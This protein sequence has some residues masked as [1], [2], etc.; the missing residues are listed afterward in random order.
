MFGNATRVLTAAVSLL[1]AP[2]AASAES[3]VPGCFAPENL[4]RLDYPIERSA[5][6]LAERQALKIVA[7]GSSSTFGTGATSAAHSYPSRLEVELRER[8][9]DTD[10][11]VLNR[12]IGGEDAREML[13][14][15]E[16]SVLV[17]KPDLVL[18]Q[19]GTNAITADEK[20][21]AEA[22][23]VRAGL[24]RLRARGIDVVLIDPQYAPKVIA[25]R[26]ANP[27]VH[28]LHDTAY[29][30][31]VSVFHRFAVMDYWRQTMKI[32]FSQFTT[33]D[34][35]HMN[36]WGYHCF[37]RLLADALTQAA[38]RSTAVSANRMMLTSVRAAIR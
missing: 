7:L 10:I 11:V 3:A 35:L 37:G 31:N 38:N 20:P 27:I 15:L 33:A 5:T 25:K 32:P 24:M 18:W 34:D 30:Q 28:V 29:R 16:K 9:P 1:L 17:E 14:R 2:V 19:V 13:A 21:A 8:F 4:T 22:A 36:D 26:H 12:G 6:R 23:L